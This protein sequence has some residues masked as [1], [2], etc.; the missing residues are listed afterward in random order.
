M[1]NACHS[2]IRG[3]VR[4][5]LRNIVTKVIKNVTHLLHKYV[6]VMPVENMSVLVNPVEEILVEV[7]PRHLWDPYFQYQCKNKAILS[8]RY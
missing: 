6:G 1:C 7:T 5:N 3:N 4:T 8:F 2:Q